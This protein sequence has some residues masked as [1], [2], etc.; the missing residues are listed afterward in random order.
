M[1]AKND[2]SKIEKNTHHTIIQ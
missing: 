2:I 1:E